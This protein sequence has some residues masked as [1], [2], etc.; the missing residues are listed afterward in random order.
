MTVANKVC[1]VTGAGR[2]T[3]SVIATHLSRAGATVV[4]A[5]IDDARGEKTAVGLER[6]SYLHLDVRSEAA[7]QAA[8][9]D[10]MER[11]GRIDVLVN[12]AAVLHMGSIAHTGTADFTRLYEVNTLGPFLGIKTVVPFMRAAGGGSIVNVGSVDGMH[13]MNGITAYA[14]S[15][16]GLRGLT[17]SAAMELGRDRIRVNQVCPSGGNAEMFAPW[18]EQL[19]AAADDVAGYFECRAMPWPGELDDIAAAVVFLAGDGSRYCTGHDLVV[20]GGLTAGT[21][22]PAFNNL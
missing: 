17:K 7:W 4:I 21:F 20:D 18:A 6:A 15:K 11:F 22:V 5:D 1:L 16:W 13:G 3:G 8:V 14:A 9:D 19:A 12:N 2:G 10:C